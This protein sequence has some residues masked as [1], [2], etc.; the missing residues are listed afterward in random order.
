MIS[1]MVSWVVESVSTVH[2]LPLYL[3]PQCTSFFSRLPS[4]LPLL[5]TCSG[6]YGNFF[7]PSFRRSSIPCCLSSSPRGPPRSPRP[8]A[9]CD[10]FM[11]LRHY[12]RMVLHEH[13]SRPRCPSSPNPIEGLLLTC[14]I[15]LVVLFY[16]RAR[17]GDDFACG[18]CRGK[19]VRG[20]IT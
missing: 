10:C 19:T 15:F 18:V 11:F 6:M 13:F 20:M 5:H 12:A 8:L 7:C 17:V 2:E 3:C 14:A 4:H 9:R 16:M 1:S